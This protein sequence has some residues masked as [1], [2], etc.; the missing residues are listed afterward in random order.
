MESFEEEHN[1]APAVVRWEPTS[2]VVS[3]ASGC[4]SPVS[5][6][7]FQPGQVI[8]HMGKLGVVQACDKCFVGLKPP[9]CK[10]STSQPFYTVIMDMGK[11]ESPEDTRY[12]AQ[13]EM[14]LWGDAN[15]QEGPPRIRHSDI[16]AHF[17]LGFVPRLREFVPARV[18]ST[19]FRISAEP[20]VL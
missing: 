10:A 8:V 19:T 14:V 15:V 12:I 20:A 2:S 1:F 13:E 18:E 7:A 6:C 5:K 3:A 11:V 4:M 17:P 16:A 9:R